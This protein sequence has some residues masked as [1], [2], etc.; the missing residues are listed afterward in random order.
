MAKPKKKRNKKDN[1]CKKSSCRKKNNSG[2]RTPIKKSSIK[3]KITKEELKIQNEKKLDL[4]EKNLEE[5]LAELKNPSP[6]NSKQLEQ[7]TSPGFFKEVN[8]RSANSSWKPSTSEIQGNSSLENR[9]LE[10]FEPSSE[11]PRITQEISD[12]Q[13]KEISYQENV[14]MYLP[15]ERTLITS[16]NRERFLTKERETPLSAIS[17]EEPKTLSPTKYNFLSTNSENYD[18]TQ[19]ILKKPDENARNPFFKEFKPEYKQLKLRK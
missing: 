3:K 9:S 19:I 6:E 11:E 5:E 7:E 8:P 16:E 2:K 12:D 17:E 15:N 10:N 14:P 1:S 18:P 13:E 4:E